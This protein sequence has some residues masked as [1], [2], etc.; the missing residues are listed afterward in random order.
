MIECI[1][2]DNAE[3]I[4]RIDFIDINV[5]SLELKCHSTVKRNKT[6]LAKIGD[7]AFSDLKSAVE[8]MLF[9]KVT[10]GD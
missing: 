3:I 7:L 6:I 9:G 2:K 8:T 5:K 1:K 10:L 4:F